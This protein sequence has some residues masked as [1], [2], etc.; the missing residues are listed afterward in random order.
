M[1]AKN[2]AARNNLAILR[3]G[4]EIDMAHAREWNGTSGFLVI[5]MVLLWLELAHAVPDSSSSEQQLRRSIRTDEKG[6]QSPVP[7]QEKSTCYCVLST[8][9]LSGVSV[10]ATVASGIGV[11]APV[12]A[13]TANTLMAFWTMAWPGWISMTWGEKTNFTVGSIATFTID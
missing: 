7:L 2:M 12:L 9:R 6:H 4:I 1:A 5:R 13:L 3:K 11:S 10:V 8:A